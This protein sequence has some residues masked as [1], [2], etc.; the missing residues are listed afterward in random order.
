M[1]SLFLSTILLLLGSAEGSIAPPR[2]QVARSALN[3]R[4]GADLPIS[5]SGLT[6]FATAYFGVHGALG[7]A[8]ASK[9]WETFD[10]SIEPGS[11]AAAFG[12]LNGWCPLGISIMAYI[13]QFTSLSPEKTVAY[14]SLPC[15]F[16]FLKYCFSGNLKKLGFKEGLGTFATLAVLA[17]VYM[18]L[19]GTGDLDIATKLLYVP[20]FVWGVMGLLKSDASVK[21]LGL[22]GFDTRKCYR[23]SLVRLAIGRISQAFLPPSFSLSQLPI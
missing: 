13:S 1:K 2:S 5:K 20:P 12:E 14:G 21:P 16:W 19:S 17:P 11:L 8:D 22:S 10:I 4:G 23:M 6:K 15:F 7:A 3:L 9:Y 18:V